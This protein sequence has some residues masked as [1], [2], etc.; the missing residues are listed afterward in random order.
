[1][2]D[3]IQRY[4]CGLQAIPDRSKGEA[5]FVLV[6]RKAFFFDRGDKNAVFDECGAA[7]AHSRKPEYVHG[8]FPVSCFSLC[9]AM[10]AG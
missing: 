10:A 2:F 3:V 9:A 5:A 1:M 6:S 8:W 7:F 4:S